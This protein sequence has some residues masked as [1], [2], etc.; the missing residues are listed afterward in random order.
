VPSRFWTHLNITT[1]VWI[2]FSTHKEARSNNFYNPLR[3]ILFWS[4]RRGE[5]LC[6][7]DKRNVLNRE[8]NDYF[9]QWEHAV[10]A[11]S[12]HLILFWNSD[13]IRVIKPRIWLNWS[14]VVPSFHLSNM[15]FG[16]LMTNKEIPIQNRL[17]PN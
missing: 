15:H 2:H 9:G 7:H 6:A 10:C 13:F 4:F 8:A 11:S 12:P 1:G 5:N 16:I 14:L 17:E 3:T